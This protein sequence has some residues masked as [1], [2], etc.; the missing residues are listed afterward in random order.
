MEVTEF[1]AH[2]HNQLSISTSDSITNAAP[3]ISLTSLL[4]CSF[5]MSGLIAWPPSVSHRQLE[6]VP[7]ARTLERRSKL[8]V[9]DNPWYRF[10]EDEGDSLGEDEDEESKE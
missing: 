5:M 8:L 9:L 7:V 2:E 4:T 3:N 10:G 1:L 6:G